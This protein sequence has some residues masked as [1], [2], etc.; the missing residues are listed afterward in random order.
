MAKSS[1]RIC[2]IRGRDDAKAFVGACQSKRHGH[3]GRA[4]AQGLVDSGQAEWVREKYLTA[5]GK[6]RSRTLSIVRLT[7]G[8][9]WRKTICRAGYAS[10]AVMQLVPGG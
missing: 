4:T 5:R 7:E 9:V 1:E 8:R 10:I 6:E 2:V 3:V